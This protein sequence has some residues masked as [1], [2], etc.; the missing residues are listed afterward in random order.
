[1]KSLEKNP[2]LWKGENVLPEAT[3]LMKGQVSVL[4]E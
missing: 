1:M 2:Q 4:M 3:D